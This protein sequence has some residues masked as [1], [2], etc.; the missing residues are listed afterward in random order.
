MMY[1]I[2]PFFK[3]FLLAIPALAGLAVAFNLLTMRHTIDWRTGIQRCIKRWPVILAITVVCGILCMGYLWSGDPYNGSFKISYTYPNASK[4]MTPNGTPLNANEIFSDEVLEALLQ[5]YPEW[6]DLSVD[7]LRNAMYLDYVKQRSSVSPDDLYVST[8]YIVNYISTDRTKSLNKDELM[9]ALSE[10]YYDYFLSSYGRKTDL[11]E[12]DYSALSDLDYLDINR[13]FSSR[14]AILVKYMELCRGEN[15]S[16]VSEVT[17]ESFNSIQNKAQ[18]FRN[19]SLERFKSYVLKYG[20]SVNRGQYISRLNFENRLEDVSYMKNLAAYSVRLAA[21][22]RYDGDI[23]RSVLVPTRD[24]AGEYYQSR[25]KIGT[26]YFANE[27]NRF[28]GYATE[29]QLT[30]ETNNYHINCL[31]AA[32][33]GSRHREK[34]DEMVEA[35]KSEIMAI[36]DLA[37]KTIQDYDNQTS[38]GYINFTF[39]E[40]NAALYANIKKTLLYCGVLFCGMGAVLLTDHG[41]LKGRKRIH[42]AGN[43]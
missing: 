7:E 6:G 16:F 41:L 8:E 29:N 23:T 15:R 33:G 42:P 30:I 27:A 4:G 24:D 31:V 32:N 28:L 26:D 36:S 25:T 19:V 1:T 13:Y 21:I 43:A 9:R 37:I 40:K 14:A 39:Q 34:T 35:L 20:V 10:V 18:N 3:L 17:G 2:R 5:R 11:L 22:D 38:N 12:D